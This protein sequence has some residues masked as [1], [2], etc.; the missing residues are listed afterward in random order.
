MLVHDH[1]YMVDKVET[2]ISLPQSKIASHLCLH[3]H[4]VKLQA[5]HPDKH[6]HLQLYAK[7]HQQQDNPCTL[8]SIQDSTGSYRESWVQ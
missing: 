8:A 6:T 3:D 4:S 7:Q 2:R 5:D 1:R